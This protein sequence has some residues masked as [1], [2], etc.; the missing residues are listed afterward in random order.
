MN[1]LR[2]IPEIVKGDELFMKVANIFTK[3][4]NR[5]M[6]VVIQEPKIQVG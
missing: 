1:I 5:E 4:E 6:F 3:M 2:E